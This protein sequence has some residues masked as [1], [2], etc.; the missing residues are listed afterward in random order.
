MAHR[1]ILACFRVHYNTCFG[2]L[3]M[4]CTKCWNRVLCNDRL[5]LDISCCYP[6]RCT[7][8]RAGVA[9]ILRIL[10]GLC[11]RRLTVFPPLASKLWNSEKP[12]DLTVFAVTH[13]I[14]MGLATRSSLVGKSGKLHCNGIWYC[15]TFVLRFFCDLLCIVSVSV[16]LENRCLPM[17]C[18]RMVQSSF[19]IILCILSCC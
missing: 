16:S 4:S 9:E 8:L 13:S 15:T 7:D 2:P 17:V 19:R 1:T 5:L 18:Y 6:E 12:C 14:F 10:K 3:W 11:N